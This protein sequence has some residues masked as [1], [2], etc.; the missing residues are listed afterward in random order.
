MTT[1][2]TISFLFGGRAKLGVTPNGGFITGP[3]NKSSFVDEGRVFMNE[4]SFMVERSN[5][6]LAKMR[7][8]EENGLPITHVW[9]IYEHQHYEDRLWPEIHLS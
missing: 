7:F 3:F 1:P 8:L 6:G 2:Y 5:L 9:V 4:R